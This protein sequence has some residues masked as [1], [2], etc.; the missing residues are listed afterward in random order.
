MLVLC[1]VIL[2]FVGLFVF[3]VW[4]GFV[5]VGLGLFV[6]DI[7][8]CGGDCVGG[9]VFGDVGIILCVDW[10]VVDIVVVCG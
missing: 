1:G 2:F 6:C 9:L 4:C 3:E 5:G 7:V 10:F 8:L